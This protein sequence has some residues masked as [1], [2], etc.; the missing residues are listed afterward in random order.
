M[1]KFKDQLIR[2]GESH[3]A[4]RPHLREILGFLEKV[5]IQDE[6]IG[7]LLDI[8]TY[9]ELMVNG[10]L[11]ATNV[12]TGEVIDSQSREFDLIGQ[13]L[14]SGLDDRLTMEL[15]QELLDDDWDVFDDG[16]AS[17]VAATRPLPRYAPLI[18]DNVEKW[19]RQS[20][21][22]AGDWKVE[23]RNLERG[24][25][26]LPRFIS[27]LRQDMHWEILNDEVPVDGTLREIAQG[28]IV[29]EWDT[30]ASLLAFI[31]VLPFRS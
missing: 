6:V 10:H 20:S 25:A 11:V 26:S 19:N 9:R 16:S 23:I 2:L 4:L 12:H 24:L 27:D 29:V 17:T 1:T 15:N 7:T 22:I 30:D 14:V 5:S 8:D 13:D 3:Q 31:E 21:G 18:S 28:T